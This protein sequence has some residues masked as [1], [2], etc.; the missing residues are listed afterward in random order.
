MNIRDVPLL[1][2]DV[3]V[4]KVGN[5]EMFHSCN[6][7]SNLQGYSNEKLVC[8][9]IFLVSEC[10]YMKNVCYVYH[11]HKLQFHHHKKCRIHA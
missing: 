8:Y 3:R 7:L 9:S 10:M 2:H 6:E 1:V 11:I 5:K 4:C